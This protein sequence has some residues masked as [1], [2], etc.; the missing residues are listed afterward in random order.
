MVRYGCESSCCGALHALL[1]GGR[2]PFLEDLRHVFTSEGKDRVASLLDDARV[3]PRYGALY[4]AL[5]SARLQ[6]R[7]AVL[8]IQD[9]RPCSPTLYLVLPCV[10]LNR[11]KKDT[12]ILCGIYAADHRQEPLRVEYVGL[13]D[14]PAAY[15]IEREHDRYRVADDQSTSIRP[16][17]DHRELVLKRWQQS[18]RQYGA[19]DERLEKIHAAVTQKKH[20]D[21]EMART[22][23]KSLLLILADLSPVSAAVLLFGQGVAGIHHAFRAH[24]LAA[25]VARDEESRKILDEIH[26]RVDQLDPKRSRALIELLVREHRHSQR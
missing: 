3:E 26:A 20:Y 24:R 6:A 11:E 9:Y 25:E 7:R 4:A 13:G 8:D 19:R 10:T 14:D 21:R 5:V 15:R 2:Q 12:E 18:S 16:A 23:L 22:L 1:A 17:R